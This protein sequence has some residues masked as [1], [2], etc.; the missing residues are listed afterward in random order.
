MAQRTWTLT[1]RKAGRA[2]EAKVCLQL[3]LTVY[4]CLQPNKISDI[5][6]FTPEMY[7]MNRKKRFDSFFKE[8]LCLEPGQKDTLLAKIL[9]W[10][11]G[12]MFDVLPLLE[13][14]LHPEP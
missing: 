12:M 1:A 9:N 14:P 7:T 4:N 13:E 6:D 10:S 11:P 8:K 2:P 5:L 3:M